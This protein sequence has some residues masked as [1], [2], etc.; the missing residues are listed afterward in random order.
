MGDRVLLP[1]EICDSSPVPTK[2][3][4]ASADADTE[5]VLLPGEIE[6]DDDSDNKDDCAD[7]PVML[8]DMV[9]SICCHKRCIEKSRLLMQSRR[10]MP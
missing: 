1:D 7:S 5:I 3:R 4:P 9:L 10:G 2:K 6:S 8:P